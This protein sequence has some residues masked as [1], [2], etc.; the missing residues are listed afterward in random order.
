MEDVGSVS[1]NN[2][3]VCCCV[4]EDF[5]DEYVDTYDFATGVAECPSPWDK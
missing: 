4:V 1:R 2:E 5:F 3:D